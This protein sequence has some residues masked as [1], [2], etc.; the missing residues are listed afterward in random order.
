MI[1]SS[2]TNIEFSMYYYLPIK[3][4]VIPDKVKYLKLNYVDINCDPDFIPKS[5]TH[6]KFDLGCNY[7]SIEFKIPETVICLNISGV[8]NPIGPNIIP[9]SVDQ[10]YIFGNYKGEIT[11]DIVLSCY[12]QLYCI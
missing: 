3:R 5:V 9:D 10:N 6:L 12:M 7:R 8:Y 4:G 1:P 11:D 2:V